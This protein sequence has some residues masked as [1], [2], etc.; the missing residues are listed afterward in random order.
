MTLNEILPSP[1]RDATCLSGDDINDAYR[2]TLE[3]YNNGTKDIIVLQNARNGLFEAGVNLKNQ[4]Y[5]L[6]VALLNL[7]NA[8]GVPFGS[9]SGID[10]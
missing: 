3:A 8:L 10:G 4:A 7:E 6:A 5:N 9:L 1:L 2:L